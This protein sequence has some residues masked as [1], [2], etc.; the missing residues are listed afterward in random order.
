MSVTAV[1]AAA[2]MFGFAYRNMVFASA[3][4]N[5]RLTANVLAESSPVPDD[6]RDTSDS[7]WGQ[8][9]VG[10]LFASIAVS[11]YLLRVWWLAAAFASGKAP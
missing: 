1:I 10:L 5:A 9:L 8:T 2:L 6:V 3:Q 4:L 7:G 11:F